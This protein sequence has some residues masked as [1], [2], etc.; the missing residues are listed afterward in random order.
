MSSPTIIRPPH[1][2]EE[3]LASLPTSTLVVI[4][5]QRTYTTGPLELSEI[6]AAVDHTAALLERARSAG[7]PVIHVQHDSGP[8]SLFDISAE[9]GAFIE[10]VAPREGEEIVVKTH[11]NSFFQ[12]DLDRLLRGH[13]KDHLLIAG[14]MTHMCVDSTSRAGFDLGYAVTVVGEATATR[15]LPGTE[16]EIPAAQ[17]K[18]STLAA[19]GDTFAVVVPTEDLIPA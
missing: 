17:V 2:A 3:E 16:G 1:R 6:A 13:A 19:L 4:D 18:A 5:A 10:A 9:S 12:T 11:P 7:T 14:F 15:P 8:G